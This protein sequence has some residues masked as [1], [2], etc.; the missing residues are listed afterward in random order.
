MGAISRSVLSVPCGS[1]SRPPA[2]CPARAGREAGPAPFLR[3]P[4]ASKAQR[5]LPSSWRRWRPSRVAALVD[6]TAV[7]FARAA[8]SR[9]LGLGLGG[10]DDLRGLRDLG[11]E[12]HVVGDRQRSVEGAVG[13]PLSSVREEVWRGEALYKRGL[14]RCAAGAGS[15]KVAPEGNG[16]AAHRCRSRK[17]SSECSSFTPQFTPKPSGMMPWPHGKECRPSP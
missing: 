3:L 6:R 10:G 7:S 15:L 9:V 14:C 16:A 2:V 12:G 1:A 11:R 17:K 5:R 4:A 8:K 13:S